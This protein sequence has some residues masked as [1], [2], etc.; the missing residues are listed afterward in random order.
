MGYFDG[1]DAVRFD[2]RT[3]TA[4]WPSATTTPTPSVLGKP[5][6]RTPALRRLLVALL[7]LGRQ[8][9]LRRPDLPAP[10]VSPA[11][12]WRRRKRPRRRR[13]RPLPPSWA[14]LFYAFHDHDIRPEGNDPGREPCAARGD[15]RLSGPRRWRPGGPTA[16]LGDG[17]LVLR[18]AA[19]CRARRPTPTRRCSP[20]APPS[21]APAWARPTGWAAEN[22]VLWGGREGLRDPLEHRPSPR[23]LEQMG[24]SS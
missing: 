7:R 12:R 16:S 11:P 13:L 20:I 9:S 21:C 5:L 1:I 23:E 6:S 17:Q 4:T 8:R 10:L 19:T 14:S 2:A 3:G 15:H 22:Y 24:P 18:T